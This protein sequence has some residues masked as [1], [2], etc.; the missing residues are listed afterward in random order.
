MNNVPITNRSKLDKRAF[1]AVMAGLSAL[2][3][4]FSGLAL[5]LLDGALP[6]QERHAWMAVH[7]VL[8]IVFVVFAAWHVIINRRGL[9]NSLRK[10]AAGG[11]RVRREIW[12][13]LLIIA[14]LIALSWGHAAVAAS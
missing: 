1:S 5:H 2:C 9:V 8:G 12:L 14:A 10:A 7:T 3:L 13:A 11:Y 6:S 4:P